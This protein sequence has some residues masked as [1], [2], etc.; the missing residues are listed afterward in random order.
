MVLHW[1]VREIPPSDK[2]RMVSGGELDVDHHDMTPQQIHTI[3][4]SFAE[5]SRHDQVAG[6]VFYRRLFELDPTLRPLFKE[7]I[8]VQSQKLIDM[9]GIMIAM[10]EQPLGLEMELRAMGARHFGYGVKDAHY[11]IVGQALLDML[12]ETLDGKFTPEVRLAWS[13]LYQAVET[14][15]KEGAA[16]VETAPL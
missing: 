16:Q 3:R 13:E 4:K 14:L 2:S 11:A 10:L 12:S 15:M 9:L 7:D 6:L 5:L 8:E 1:W